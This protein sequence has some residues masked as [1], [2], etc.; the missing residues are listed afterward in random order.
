MVSK[1]VT[2][3][4]PRTEELKGKSV[5]S[6]IYVGYS[7]NPTFK[8]PDILYFRQCS[9]SQLATGDVI[10]FS[11]PVT[12]RTV[13]HRIIAVSG[14]KFETR[15]DNNPANDPGALTGKDI[16]GKVEYYQRG[17]KLYKVS[18]G[19][20]GVAR[21][22]LL[23]VYKKLMNRRSYFLSAV[24]NWIVKATEDYRAGI[25]VKKPMCL[26][27]KRPWGEELIVRMGKTR[28]GRRGKD[29]LLQIK[30]PFKLMVSE[31]QIREIQKPDKDNIK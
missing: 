2:T 14:N 15:G 11:N 18:G 4:H 6:M 24:Y 1:E 25:I 7:M 21:A 31:H 3:S 20:R 19:S 23:R 30:P 5:G 29:G 28:I 27:V 10:V 17:R 9:P 12:G 8:G 22:Y 13:T 26:H 16:L